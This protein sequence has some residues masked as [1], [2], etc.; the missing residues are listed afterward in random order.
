MNTG[1]TQ[2][3]TDSATT[4]MTTV[5]MNR[6]DAFLQGAKR[7]TAWTVMVAALVIAGCATPPAIDA[8]AIPVAPAQFKEGDGRW[9]VAP[10]AESRAR[11]EWWKAFADPV[12]DQLI[13][14]ADVDNASIQVAAARVKQ[15]RALVAS[16]RAN[17][18]PQ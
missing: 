17:E 9:T 3:N 6:R 8:N 18:M 7:R 1:R 16:T 11:G 4:Y 12:L 2:M 5:P 10:P 15:A 14:R 13:A